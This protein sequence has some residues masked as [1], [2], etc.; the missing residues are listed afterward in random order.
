M[1]GVAERAIGAPLERRDGPA[2]VTGR[3][4]Y[5]YEQPVVDPLYL[6]PLE[7]AVARGRITSID[8]SEAEAVD[9]VVLV[10][11]HR[12]APRLAPDADRELWVC[13]DEEIHFRNQFIGAVVAETSEAA[14]QAAG[15][16]RVAY[17]EDAHDVV[18]RA[19]HPGLYAPE[20]VNAG[21]ATDSI[22]GD[23][24]RALAEAEVTVDQT[25]TTPMEHHNPMEP[26]TTVAA[27]HGEDG[28]GRFT[29][30]DS[31]QGATMIQSLLAPALGV[32]PSR[33]R[34]ISPYVGG[35]FGSKAQPHPHVMLAV[36][37]AQLTGG[38]AVKCA[39]TRRQ[40]FTQASHRSPSIQ[41]VRL[42]ADRQGRL[43]ALAHGSIAQTARFKEFVE[44]T[45]FATRSMY[46]AEHRATTHRAV[47]LDVS[48]PGIYRA[49]GETPG[50]FALES[51][52]DELALAC[53]LDPIELRVRNEPTSD[54]ESGLPFSTRAYVA[55][56]R[57]GARRFRWEGR[58]PEPGVRRSGDWLI[59]TGVSGCVYPAYFLRGG[60]Q[61]AVEALPD[62]RYRVELAASDI[63]TGAWT[64]LAQ[65]AADALTVPVAD[66]DMAIGDSALPPATLAGGSMGLTHW[67][68]AITEAARVFRERYGNGPSP[69]D[70]V[71]A[72][73]PENPHVGKVSMHAF[74]A[75]FAEVRVNADTGEVRVSRM[76]GVYDLGRVVNPRTTRS[77]LIGG[78]IMGMSMALH[79]ESVVDPR[80]GHVVNCDLAQY[81]IPTHADV[82]E[83]EAVWLD[84]FDSCYNP[85]GAK[86][87]G[88]TGIVGVAAAL[89]NAAHHA[90]GIRVRALPLTPDRFLR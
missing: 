86:G 38:R 63:G 10:L 11:T 60:S 29:L 81:H 51:A 15:L 27:F 21:I 85:M 62:G 24:E 90:T 2:K 8:T 73:E 52:M 77:Q 36:L 45:T 56:L 66:V 61:A 75:Q 54:P 46:A 12:N 67:G 31:N 30:H 32:D 57:E 53:R 49:P 48:V 84:G 71:V 3:A 88:E 79:E 23:V 20:T 68:T 50:F 1:T 74:G 83:I 40:T 28:S 39:L 14:R 13:Q 58:D 34:I 5:A 25:Y 47:A 70:R 55:C 44:Q 43:S 6:F 18:L 64:A 16:V 80:F 78:M 59:G 26:H 69:G 82:E 87:V 17:E 41:R 19:D 33:L 9:G 72:T 65:I 4:A 42:G 89:A 35:A 7:A 22:F 37:A 76:L